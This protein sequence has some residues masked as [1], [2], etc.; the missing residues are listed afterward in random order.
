METLYFFLREKSP[1][2]RHNRKGNKGKR[3]EQERQSKKVLERER[4]GNIP[5]VYISL[6]PSLSRKKEKV[7][8]KLRTEKERYNIGGRREIERH[9]V[10]EE[11][12]KF[13]KSFAL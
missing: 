10:K 2:L 8:K 6:S 4:E 11:K 7:H 13:C 1:S 5:K 12:N 9:S 3:L